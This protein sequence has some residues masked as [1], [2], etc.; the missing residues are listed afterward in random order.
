MH[1][2]FS[3][4]NT[5]QANSIPYLLLS[6]V[7]LN[8]CSVFHG[9]PHQMTVTFYWFAPPLPPHTWFHCVALAF[10]AL[11]LDQAALELRDNACP[12]LLSGRIKGLH[13]HRLS[14]TL[15]QNCFV[16]SLVTPVTHHLD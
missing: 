9:L 11:T 14:V 2:W 16:L 3:A 15:L 8:I 1:N 7:C 13:R 10:L 5:N 12:C 6:F 4:T